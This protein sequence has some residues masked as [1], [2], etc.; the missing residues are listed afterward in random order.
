MN[1]PRFQYSFFTGENRNEQYVVRADTMAELKGQIYELN[2]YLGKI[3]AQPT[4]KVPS[5]PVAAPTQT[6]QHELTAEETISKYGLTDMLALQMI[7][8]CKRC[9][10][11]Q[12]YNPKSGKVF[13]KA[14][15]W[16]GGQQ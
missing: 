1:D 16:L 13:C 9:H 3:E 2:L 4:V 11:P 10:G 8:P 6:F 7:T 12:V 5:A 14:K 15:C